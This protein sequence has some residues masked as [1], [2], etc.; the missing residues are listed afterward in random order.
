MHLLDEA[1]KFTEVDQCNFQPGI[2]I[3]NVCKLV[4]A[5]QDP[6]QIPGIFRKPG[7]DFTSKRNVVLLQEGYGA[8][9]DCLQCVAQL[10]GRTLE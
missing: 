8:E 6:L 2:A 5:V 4:E 1:K 3:Q 7:K 10:M 9:L